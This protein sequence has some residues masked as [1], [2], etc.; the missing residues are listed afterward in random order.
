MSLTL[1]PEVIK[2]NKERDFCWSVNFCALR[3]LFLT[4]VTLVS[5][6]AT[7][8]SDMALWWIKASLI[9]HFIALIW[10]SQNMFYWMTD[11]WSEVVHCCSVT[12]AAQLCGTLQVELLISLCLWLAGLLK[13]SS[14]TWIWTRISK[15]SVSSPEEQPKG[16]SP[17]IR[18]S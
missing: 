12:W 17:L 16:Q 3:H 15:D 4:G 8:A 2:H 10:L 6:D 18:P 5:D 14:W 13:H 11:I 7:T 1:Y 9:I